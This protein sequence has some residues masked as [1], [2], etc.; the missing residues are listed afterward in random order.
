MREEGKYRE[1]RENIER[2]GKRLRGEGKDREGR[3]SPLYRTKIKLWG[4]NFMT[5]FIS[6]AF[7]L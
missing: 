3:D 2:S 4:I 1:E 6:K 7:E 5:C